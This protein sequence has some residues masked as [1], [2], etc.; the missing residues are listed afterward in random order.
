[1]VD[2]AYF[3]DFSA[4]FSSNKPLYL[5]ACRAHNTCRHRPR[6]G[7]RILAGDFS[8]FLSDLIGPSRIAANKP[9]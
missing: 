1:M 4:I 8:D 7:A 9:G 3:K 6:A 5:R 2:Q